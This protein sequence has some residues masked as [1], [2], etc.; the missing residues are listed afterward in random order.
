MEELV[1]GV[2]RIAMRGFLGQL[3]AAHAETR[4]ER[5]GDVFGPGDVSA[6][7]TPCR[8]TLPWDAVRHIVRLI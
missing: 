7:G 3:Y 6:G 2:E 8:P 5:L 1:P 4:E